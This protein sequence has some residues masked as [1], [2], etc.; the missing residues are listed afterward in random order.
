[1]K[2][3]KTPTSQF[4]LIFVISLF[5]ITCVNV[6]LSTKQVTS[7]K[8]YRVTPPKPPFQEV[9]IAGTDSAWRNLEAQSTISVLSECG[10]KSTYEA[11]EKD[12]RSLFDSIDS[13]SRQELQINGLNGVQYKIVGTSYDK[14]TYYEHFAYIEENCSYILNVSNS[15]DV[16]DRTAFQEFIKNFRIAK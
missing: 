1:M 10:S 9:V 2:Y 13:E 16:Q 11:I 7:S 6:N 12:V 3:L 5:C 8:N 15:Q 4:A 14:K